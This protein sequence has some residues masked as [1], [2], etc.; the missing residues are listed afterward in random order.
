MSD[1][2]ESLGF[3]IGWD[4]AASG[5][6]LWENMMEFPCIVQGHSAGKSHFSGTHPSADKYVKKLMSIKFSAW[7]RGRVVDDSVT[8]TYLRLIDVPYC[9]VTRV[10][11][12]AGTLELTD[13]SV[14]RV[15]NDAAYAQGNLIIMS[16]EANKVKGTHSVQSFK[17]LI[18]SLEIKALIENRTEFSHEGLSVGSL[19]RL[20]YLLHINQDFGSPPLPLYIWSPPGMYFA[21]DNHTLKCLLSEVFLNDPAVRRSILIK[22]RDVSPGKRAKKALDRIDHLMETFYWELRKRKEYGDVPPTTRDMWIV[23]DI[24]TSII[25]ND[26]YLDWTFFLEGDLVANIIHRFRNIICCRT[27]GEG[28]GHLS[29]ETKGY[30]EETFAKRQLR[31]Q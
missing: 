10:K 25:F 8:A 27:C 17:S 12:T 30:T 15:N 19:G 18:D 11:L 24:W 13:W 28:M 16:T 5:L 23:E 26:A 21:S 22:L 7:K 2:D 9:P 4:I 6:R 20:L 1:L 14:D 29:K 31:V 3:R